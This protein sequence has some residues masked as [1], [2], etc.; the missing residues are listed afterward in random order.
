MYDLPEEPRKKLSSGQNDERSVATD[1]DSSTG[2]RPINISI[3]SSTK[4]P[5]NDQTFIILFRL[6]HIGFSIV[7]AG[8]VLYIVLFIIPAVKKSGADETRVW[9]QL[10]KTVYPV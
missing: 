4:Q 1:D 8:S 6:L 3:P 7:W 2:V 5:M 9:L 10:N